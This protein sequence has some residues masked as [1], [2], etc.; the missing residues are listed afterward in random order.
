M[1]LVEQS[2]SRLQTVEH[3]AFMQESHELRTLARLAASTAWLSH[4]VL[5][6]MLSPSSSRIISL[7]SF[8]LYL[9]R[10]TSSHSP[11][12]LRSVS[13]EFHETRIHRRTRA[14]TQT[15]CGS[16]QL[17]TT[18]TDLARPTASPTLFCFLCLLVLQRKN[19]QTRYERKR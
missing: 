17:R 16:K 12:L 10:R 6:F 7:L 5:S 4:S 13:T 11:F 8:Q 18:A 15:G 2:L 3:M 19:T 1:V 14:N 9:C